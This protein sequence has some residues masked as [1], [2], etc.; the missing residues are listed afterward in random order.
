MSKKESDMIQELARTPSS[1]TTEQQHELL[2]AAEYATLA[3]VRDFFEKERAKIQYEAGS[4]FARV[5]HD[6]QMHRVVRCTL[7]TIV[8]ERRR[9]TAA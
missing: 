3:A 9:T 1:V 4:S 2:N 7:S 6:T 5:L 8:H